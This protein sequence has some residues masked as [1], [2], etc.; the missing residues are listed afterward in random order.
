M[1]FG[2]NW[3]RARHRFYKRVQPLP[4]SH[5]KAA[6]PIAWYRLGRVV[7]RRGE[8]WVKCK[9]VFRGY[10]RVG[11]ESAIRVQVEVAAIEI[12]GAAVDCVTK[13]SDERERQTHQC[14][15]RAHGRSLAELEG[16]HDRSQVTE[17]KINGHPASYQGGYELADDDQQ[18]WN[19]SGMAAVPALIT[20]SVFG[21]L[22]VANRVH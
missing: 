8:K 18:G 17:Q 16:R 11:S 21:F 9:V 15:L 19:R 12:L 4:I 7:I 6:I 10:G 2:V 14:Q 5:E 13:A 3:R 22:L 20:I 1:G